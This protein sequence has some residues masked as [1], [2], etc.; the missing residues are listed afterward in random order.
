MTGSGFFCRTAIRLNGWTSYS[1]SRFSARA[2][3]FLKKV[4]ALPRRVFAPR[5]PAPAPVVDGLFV[6]FSYGF[7]ARAV[8]V[9][10]EARAVV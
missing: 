10:S 7:A 2:W 4:D 9:A 3:Q 8:D 6:V 1:L 5:A